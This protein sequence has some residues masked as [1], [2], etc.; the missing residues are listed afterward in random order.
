MLRILPYV[1]VHFG[2]P[3]VCRSGCVVQSRTRYNALAPGPGLLTHGVRRRPALRGRRG[4][5]KPLWGRALF[6]VRGA[7]AC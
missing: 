1:P 4:S 2:V 7:R 6:V 5:T 3:R